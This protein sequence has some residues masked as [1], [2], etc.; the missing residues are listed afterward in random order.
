MG[1]ILNSIWAKL[2]HT[3]IN[4]MADCIQTLREGIAQGQTIEKRGDQLLVGDKTLDLATPNVFKSH[5][6]N[7]VY[8]YWVHREDSAAEY[9]KSCEE[10]QVGVVPFVD[11]SELVDLLEGRTD[12]TTANTA[13]VPAK[14]KAE[15]D[16]LIKEIR[17][18]E[19]DLIDHNKALRGSKLIDF[20]QIKRECEVKI[21]KPIL[22]SKKSSKTTGAATT[23][24]SAAL[25]NKEPII[26]M[27]PSASALLNM[28]NIK[29][30]LSEGRFRAEAAAVGGD[31][32][33][34]VKRASTKFAKPVTFLV[35]NNIEKFIVKPEYWDRVVA[36]F[37]TGQ[38]WQ[39]KNYKYKEPNVLFQRY[40]GF[41]V[42]WE[43]EPVPANIAKWNVEVVKMERNVRFKDGQVSQHLW[44]S[45]ERWMTARGFK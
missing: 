22:S 41:Y 30:F 31:T 11:R 20:S 44:E 33:L 7:T 40:K 28:S 13:A 35:I 2:G 6:L 16:V 37:T 5:N 21:I 15:E 4:A 23:G 32:I 42:G 27:S 8:F 43:G 38:E 10:A 26:L 19:I 39:F 14:R 25:K 24:L 17:A 9:I 12:G 3:F 18:N 45:L 29:E 36:I 34:K 1:K